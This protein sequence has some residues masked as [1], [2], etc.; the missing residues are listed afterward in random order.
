MINDIIL[1]ELDN[2]YVNGDILHLRDEW[3]HYKYKKLPVPRVTHIIH[4]CTLDT[5]A[6]TK[7]ANSL[8]YRHINSDQ[9]RDE[10]ALKGTLIHEAIENYLLHKSY[11]KFDKPM[12]IKVK[13]AVMNGIDGFIAFWDNYRY[14][15][16][17]VNVQLEQTIVTPYF[18]GT[19]D[20]LVTLNDG[21]NY[22]YDF[23]TTNSIRDSQFIQLA[24]YRFTLLRYYNIDLAGCAILQIDKNKPFCR[25]YMLDFSNPINVGFMN[26]CETTFISMLYTY[27]NL[28]S[29]HLAFNEIIK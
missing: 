24:A 27:Y 16:L 22:L 15:N 28:C 2:E 13:E 10:A 19:Y 8:G 29:T 21:R 23:K 11:P 6:L 26:Q 20:L 14:K 17:V 3:D 25:E 12:G 18:G 9:A 7:W 1:E 4:A 5:D